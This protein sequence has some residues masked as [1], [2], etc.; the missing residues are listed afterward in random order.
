MA[1]LDIQNDGTTDDVGTAR[2]APGAGSAIPQFA[3]NAANRQVA[4]VSEVLSGAADS[5]DDLLASEQL[6][7]P[8]QVRGFAT[9]ASETLR[10]YSDRAN[11]EEAAKLIDTL[12]SKAASHPVATAGIGAA[13]GAALGLALARLSASSNRSASEPNRAD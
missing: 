12:Q 8:D 5:I 4:R 9:S 7:L 11:P 6:P 10:K 3:I 13:I 1:E 2:S